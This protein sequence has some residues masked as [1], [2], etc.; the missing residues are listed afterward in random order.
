MVKSTNSL[1]QAFPF[2]RNTFVGVA[3]DEDVRNK[4]IIHVAKDCDITF[5]FIGSSITVSATAGMD[6]AIE[7]QT[8]T[9]TSTDVIWIS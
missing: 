9:V 6:L 8:Q 2:H 3:S 7:P 1:I 4:S 5:N